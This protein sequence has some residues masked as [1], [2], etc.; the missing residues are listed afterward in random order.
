MQNAG[1]A[2]L[3]VICES[4]MGPLQGFLST[5]PLRVGGCSRG[6]ISEARGAG[7]AAA[8]EVDAHRMRGNMHGAWAQGLGGPADPQVVWGGIN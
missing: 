2:I 5:K 1:I 8:T 7:S 6:R 3:T 4:V